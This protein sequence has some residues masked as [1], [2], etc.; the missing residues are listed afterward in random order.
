MACDARQVLVDGIDFSR[1]DTAS[2]KAVQLQLV[3]ESLLAISPETDVSFESIMQRA[4]AS[5]IARLTKQQL[6]SSILELVCEVK[7]TL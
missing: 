4:C 6:R 7:E 3:A 2:I 1:L 5:G